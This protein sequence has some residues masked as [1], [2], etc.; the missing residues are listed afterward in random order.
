[1]FGRIR[2]LLRGATLRELK[3]H[4][5]RLMVIRQAS[6]GV[7]DR[8]RAKL[9]EHRQRQRRV[10]A[11]RSSSF[12]SSFPNV[13]GGHSTDHLDILPRNTLLESAIALTIS[14]NRDARTEL[15]FMRHF[16]TG[17]FLSLASP[18]GPWDPYDIKPQVFAL[19]NYI[20]LPVFT[21]L[22]YLRLFCRRFR[23]TTRDPSGVLWADGP[24]D[25]AREE[26]SCDDRDRLPFPDVTT[27]EWWPRHVQHYL[28]VTGSQTAAEHVDRQEVQ[29][30]KDVDSNCAPDRK[31]ESGYSMDAEDLFEPVESDLLGEYKQGQSV[32]NSLKKRNRKRFRGHTRCK[33]RQ[34]REKITSGG[35]QT[36]AGDWSA[37]EREA[38]A[39]F[40]AKVRNTKPFQIK[41]ATPLPVFGPPLHPFFVGYFADVETLL[42]NASIVPEKV[43]IVLNPCSPIEFVLAR[44]ATDRV[45]Q[46]DQLLLLAYHRVERELRS[47]L[48]RFLRLYAPE[49]SWARSA[50][51]PFPTP[52]CVSGIRYEVVV[53]LQS[54]DFQKTLASL[55]AAKERCLVMGHADLDII[56]WSAAALHVREASEV[57]YERASC[58]A[59]GQYGKQ[60][61]LGVFERRGSA[62]TINVSRPADS[63]Y[64][65][66]SATYTESHA[67]FTEEL[68]LKKRTI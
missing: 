6:E 56:P 37:D 52:G 32:G 57:F 20:A 64:H 23:F 34:M 40:W 33:R 25:A 21:S 43:D 41:Q 13:C 11:T 14:E 48:H 53:L 26:Q 65:D 46:K 9:R 12:S 1:M 22:E 35:E 3:S 50:C 61:F 30:R 38:H 36:M 4:L 19:D 27:S 28:Q 68:K 29:V 18:V 63:F 59:D 17:T 16:L 62:Q 24:S 54:E 58:L 42:H 51:V 66:P 7:N 55:R 39:A 15:E 60:G 49:V 44:E 45:L 47:E 5:S 10:G 67:V 31:G 8:H 2:C